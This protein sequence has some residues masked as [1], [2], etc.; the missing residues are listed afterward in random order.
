MVWSNPKPSWRAVMALAADQHG[1]VARRQLIAMGISRRA[2]DHRLRRGRLHLVFRAVY[3]VGRPALTRYGLWMAAV[4]ACG[5]DSALSH[6]SAAAL[7]GFGGEGDQ[8]EVSVARDVRLDGI[9]AH[10][11]RSFHDLSTT[12][13]RGISVTAPIQT[14]IDMAPQRDVAELARAVNEADRLDAIRWDELQAGLE[15][16]AGQ[17]GVAKLRSVLAGFTLTDSELERMFLPVAR[18]AGLAHPLTQHKLDGFRVDFYWPDLGLVVETDGLRYHR[19]PA[20]QARDLRRDQVHT[21]AGRTPLRFS[22]WQIA[23]EPRRVEQTLR[24]V[25]RR[26]SARAA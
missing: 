18:A 16:M 12:I 5:E 22:H 24:D 17:P 19:T 23:H 10:V 3:A 1:V 20:T 9:R 14:L 11:R 13:D 4:L 25:A 2:I 6:G 21:A 15:T 7:A 26:L 8:I